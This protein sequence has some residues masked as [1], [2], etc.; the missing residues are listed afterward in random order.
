MRPATAAAAATIAGPRQLR[1]TLCTSCRSTAAAALSSGALLKLLV[2]FPPR[3][4]CSQLPPQLLHD[5][6]LLLDLCHGSLLSQH[7]RLQHRSCCCSI[8]GG[9]ACCCVPLLLRLHRLLL[10]TLAEWVRFRVCFGLQLCCRGFC[11]APGIS[12]GRLQALLKVADLPQ[13]LSTVLQLLLR[14][15]GGLLCLLQPCVLLGS[16]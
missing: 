2:L 14:L 9:R 16:G 7:Q 10:C 11:L 15:L 13:G 6:L 8:P 5:P 1:H 12:D 4:C 3:C